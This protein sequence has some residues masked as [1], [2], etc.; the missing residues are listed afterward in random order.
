VSAKDLRDRAQRR[1]IRK[2]VALHYACYLARSLRV[3]VLGTNAKN[4]CFRSL[5]LQRTSLRTSRTVR[6]ALTAF[7]LIPPQYAMARVPADPEPLA[8]L[9]HIRQGP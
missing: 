6:K 1:Y 3:V 9:A 4:L 8:Q 7:R 2:T 5:R